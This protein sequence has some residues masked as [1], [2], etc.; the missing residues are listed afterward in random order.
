VDLIVCDSWFTVV[1][2]F[3]VYDGGTALII[4]E[5]IRSSYLINFCDY[6]CTF[7]I[8]FVVRGAFED[9]TGLMHL[10]DEVLVVGYCAKRL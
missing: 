4:L 2:F 3:I 8:G 9:W 5:L 1:T 6:I 7:P 10:P